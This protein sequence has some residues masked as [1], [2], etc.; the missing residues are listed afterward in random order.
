MQWE[1][2]KSV[3]FRTLFVYHIVHTWV[4]NLPARSLCTSSKI[5]TVTETIAR[6]AS[7]LKVSQ[8]LTTLPTGG[9]WWSQLHRDQNASRFSCPSVIEISKFILQNVVGYCYD[10][11]QQKGVWRNPSTR[12]AVKVSLQTVSLKVWIAKFLFSGF[13]ISNG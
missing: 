8:W 4:I 12:G 9:C 10:W 1:K 3:L 6:S 7:W 13:F 2:E 5:E 11:L